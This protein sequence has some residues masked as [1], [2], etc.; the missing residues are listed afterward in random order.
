[1]EETAEEMRPEGKHRVSEELTYSG[2][3]HREVR[4]D[5]GLDGN[6]Q[7][8]VVMRKHTMSSKAEMPRES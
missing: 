2:G 3:M 1:M 4:K 7:L 6:R 8:S 5:A